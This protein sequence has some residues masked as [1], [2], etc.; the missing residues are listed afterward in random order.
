M[1]IYI[2]ENIKRLRKEK[3]ITQEK[4]AE[5]LNISCQAISK[6]ERCETYPD[7]TLLIPIASFFNVSTD[8]LLG[9]DNE[10]N[11]K[12]IQSYLEEYQKLSAL[13]RNIDKFNLMLKAYNE[14]PNDFRIIEKYAW[15]LYYDPT[16][17]EHQLRFE[18]HKEELYRICQRILDDC[19]IEQI[20]YSALDILGGLYVSDQKMDKALETARQFPNHYYYTANEQ[21][22]STI[23]EKGSNSWIEI[24]H[25]NIQDLCDCLIVK[26]RNN[27]LYRKLS[28]KDKIKIFNKGID[29]INVVYDDG[30]YG[31]T[32]YYLCELNIHIANC[33]IE[34]SNYDIAIEYIEK[35]LQYGKLYDELPNLYQHTSIL[36]NYLQQN[37]MN[38]NK[39]DERKL[40]AREI[41]FLNNN[42]YNVLKEKPKFIDLV[43]R[44]NSHLL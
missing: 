22:E 15:G 17:N 38:V 4:L 32:N 41:T 11:E 14:Y 39:S 34:L 24:N 10:K 31:F 6:W 13:G 23:L 25:K 18:V 28:P 1:N 26:I 42:F 20:R 37:M 36:L 44:Y 8:E 30:D 9:L 2:G 16:L 43:N 21:I 5:N 35:G 12:I 40:I 19:N 27:A 29:L 3:N 7:I 33:Y